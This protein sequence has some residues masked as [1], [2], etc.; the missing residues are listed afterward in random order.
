MM[1]AMECVGM[2]VLAGVLCVVTVAGT[3]VVMTMI[4]AVE[5]VFSNPIV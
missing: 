2:G 4:H 5:G 3:L 1:S